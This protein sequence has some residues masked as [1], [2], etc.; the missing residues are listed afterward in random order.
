M[1]TGAN[2]LEG[3]AHITEIAGTFFA[4]AERGKDVAEPITNSDRPIRQDRSDR[5]I[6]AADRCTVWAVYGAQIAQFGVLGDAGIGARYTGLWV[7]GMIVPFSIF[8][9][10]LASSFR[11]LA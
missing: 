10:I 4:I 3:T 5:R 6:G 2:G 1:P 9:S 8:A 11:S 7:A